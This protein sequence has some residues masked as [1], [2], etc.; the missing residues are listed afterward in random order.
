M[1]EAQH[2]ALP[3][4]TDLAEEWLSHPWEWQAAP[5]LFSIGRVKAISLD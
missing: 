3:C 1:F 2:D 4:L 5:A